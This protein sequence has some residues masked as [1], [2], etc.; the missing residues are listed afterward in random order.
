M[1]PREMIQ[2]NLNTTQCIVISTVYAKYH[3]CLEHL[4]RISFLCHSLICSFTHLSNKYL[5]GVFYVP[6]TVLAAG[7]ST[8]NKED[9]ILS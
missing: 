1:V 3:P 6:G 8:V 9:K 5:L 7:D 2:V 4:L